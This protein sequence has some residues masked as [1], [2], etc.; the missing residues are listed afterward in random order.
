MIDTI[1]NLSR[2]HP[3]NHHAHYYFG[4]IHHYQRLFDLAKAN[5]GMQDSK[6]TSA[7]LDLKDD[8]K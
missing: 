2:R 3:S 4:D 8:I 7:T 6:L 5:P 1:D